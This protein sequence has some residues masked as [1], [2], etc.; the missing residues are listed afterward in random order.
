MHVFF[1][2]I[3][4][5]AITSWFSR[6]RVVDHSYGFNRPIAF[7]FSSDFRLARVKVNSSHEQRFKWVSRA[8]VIGG[9]IPKGN[10]LFQFVS[11]LFLFVPLFS[12]LSKNIYLGVR[13]RLKNSKKNLPLIPCFDLGRRWSFF[14]CLEIPSNKLSHSGIIVH[15]FLFVG[16]LVW[17]WKV[18]NGVPRGKQGQQIGW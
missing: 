16:Q 9:W 17:R 18:W 10:L 5:K 8:F 6:A 1:M 14:W 7:K 4:N 11:H 12:S 2:L 3:L 13:T 15:I